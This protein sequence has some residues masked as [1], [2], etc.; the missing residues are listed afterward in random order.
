MQD[1]VHPYKKG[2]LEWWTPAFEKIF[3]EDFGG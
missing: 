3:L 1:P 2:Y